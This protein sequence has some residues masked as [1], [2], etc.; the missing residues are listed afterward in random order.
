MPA[1][2]RNEI[3][4]G[5]RE[6]VPFFARRIQRAAPSSEPSNRKRQP[7]YFFNTVKCHTQAPQGCRKAHRIWW[8]RPLGL[9][10]RTTKP[11]CVREK[12]PIVSA[13]GV[14]AGQFRVNAHTTRMT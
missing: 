11:T 5:V 9:R 8:S 10:Q 3:D 1:S 6:K 7:K 14:G 12:V 2:T 13:S 4:P